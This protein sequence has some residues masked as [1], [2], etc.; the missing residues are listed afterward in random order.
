MSRQTPFTWLTKAIETP[1]RTRCVIPL[2]RHLALSS[3][4]RD[5]LDRIQAENPDRVRLFDTTPYL[6]DLATGTC[7]TFKGK[8]LL[9]S[10][11]DHI[12]DYAAGVIGKDLNRELADLRTPAH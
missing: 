4:Y 11:T 6:C 3:K 2:A 9:Y 12:S 5:V 8:A 1:V 10:Y 7:S